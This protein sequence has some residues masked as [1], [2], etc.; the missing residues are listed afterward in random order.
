MQLH[1][2]VGELVRTPRL[3]GVFRHP[4]RR[5][6]GGLIPIT[7]TGMNLYLALFFG[8]AL[9]TSTQMDHKKTAL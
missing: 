3:A 1:L 2:W 9:Q 5:K 8:S 6:L 4:A 7:G